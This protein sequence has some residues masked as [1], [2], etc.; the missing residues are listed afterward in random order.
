MNRRLPIFCT[1]WIVVFGC[2]AAILSAA[3]GENDPARDGMREAIES[4]IDAFRRDDAAAAF[5][6]M[7]GDVRRRFSDPN[8][9]LH[10]VRSAYEPLHRSA[11]IVFLGRR[12]AGDE[13]VQQLLVKQEG[14]TWWFALYRMRREDGAWKSS[15]CVLVPTRGYR[16]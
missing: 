12:T 3:A 11:S 10:V 8:H 15:G 6:L 2:A 7:A 1:S 13:I 5:A 16:T 9:F 4:Q 14:G